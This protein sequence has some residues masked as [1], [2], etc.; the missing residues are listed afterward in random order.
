MINF[1]VGPVQSSSEVLSI[2]AEQTPYF[3]TSEFSEIMLNNEEIMLS[4]TQ[5]PPSSRVVFLTGSGTASMESVIMHTLDKNDKC[6]VIDGG[7]FGHRFVQLLELHGVP[8]TVIKLDYGMPL[9]CSDLEMYDNKGYTSF[10]VNIHETSTGVLYDLDLISDFCFRNNLFLIVDAIS[11]FLADPINMSDKGIDVLI[12]GSQKALACPP[13]VSIIVL[14]PNAL[15]RIECIPSKSMYLDLQ[16]ALKDGSRGQTPFTPAVTILR[17]IHAR[18]IEIQE[19][20]GAEK[21]I[22]RIAALSTYFRDRI[23]DF[24]FEF[25]S[26]SMSNAVTALHP[27]NCSAYDVFLELK[28][29]YGIWICPNG[30]DLKDSVFR[31]GHIGYLSKND[32]DQ[33]FLAF[34]DLHNKGIL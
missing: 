17:Q 5:A 6:L 8:H 31:V 7:S 33:L 30:G 15:N 32:Y 2:G 12:T 28:N 27:L 20:G 3:R 4:F 16:T 9:S 14:S 21:E 34:N 29:N 25:F 23:I 11:S 26:Q 24:P 18:L 22:D 10:L 19:N 13:G 1:T